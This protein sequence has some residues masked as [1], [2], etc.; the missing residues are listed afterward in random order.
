MNKQAPCQQPPAAAELRSK[1]DVPHDL[2]KKSG[3]AE[4][5]RLGPCRAGIVTTDQPVVKKKELHA[6]GVHPAS[7]DD[8]ENPDIHDIGLRQART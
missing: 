4:G 2:E 3:P 8:Q 6:N 1:L 5:L 7:L